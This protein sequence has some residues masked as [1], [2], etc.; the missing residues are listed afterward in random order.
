MCDL[1]RLVL[2]NLYPFL[3]ACALIYVVGE[4]IANVVAAFRGN[5]HD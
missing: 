1:L 3:A 4:A 5:R 2:M